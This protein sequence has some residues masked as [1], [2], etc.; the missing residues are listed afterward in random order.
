MIPLL[1]TNCS[2]LMAYYE[3]LH[4]FPASQVHRAVP[5]DHR[6]FYQPNVSP[7]LVIQ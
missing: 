5:I 4:A 7:L 3:D 2:S 6:H 1:Q